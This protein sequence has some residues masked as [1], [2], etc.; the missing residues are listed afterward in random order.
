[1]IFPTETF[2]G[3]GCLAADA[4]AVARIYQL[5][6]R[7]VQRP[8]P[9]LAADA[10]Q[11]GAVVWLEA[12]PPEL[13]ARFW[14]G[15]LSLLLPVRPGLPASLVSAGAGG[16]DGAAGKAALR[17]SPHPLAARLAR[18]AGGALTA[19]SA[20][21]SGRA[22]ARRLEELDPE[23]L[24]AL[25]ELGDLGGLLPAVSEAEQPPGGAPSTLAEPLPP[26]GDGRPRLRLLRAG[27]VSARA[28]AEAGFVCV[29]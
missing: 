29:D 25:A 8:L 17:V 20:N 12:A 13:T 3:L 23:L 10:D 18:L 1:M 16:E 21:L 27:A 9:L 15:P 22:P 24:A 7:P 28:L 26:D 2:Y 11:A 14:P 4:A 5:K 6:R 19:S